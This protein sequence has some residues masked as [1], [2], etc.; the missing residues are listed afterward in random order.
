MRD[1]KK[2]ADECMRELNSL[3]IRYANSIEF[4]VNVRAKK[5]WGQCRRK[6][7]GTYVISIN[8]EL[9]KEKNDLRGLRDTIIHEILHT[10]EGCMNHGKKWKRYAERVNKAF[11][12]NISRCA[13]AAEKGVHRDENLEVKNIDKYAIRCECCG[14]THYSSKLTKTIKHPER[15]YCGFCGGRMARVR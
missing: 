3:G 5:R 2:N 1:L 15:Y 10:C 8:V 11:G 14:R 12:Y 13:S 9:L 7:D 4:I 6:P